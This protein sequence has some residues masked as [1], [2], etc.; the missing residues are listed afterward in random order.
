[1]ISLL[2]ARRFTS[3]QLESVG[4]ENKKQLNFYVELKL[5]ILTL[6]TMCCCS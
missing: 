6:Q 4:S 1:M 2:R 3:R 5:E